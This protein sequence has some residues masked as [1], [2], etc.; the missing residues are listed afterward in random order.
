MIPYRCKQ[1]QHV[2]YSSGYKP[3]LVCKCKNT[4]FDQLVNICLLMPVGENEK[5]FLVSEPS[6]IP[7]LGQPASNRWKL[8][9]GS[10]TRPMHFTDQPAVATCKTCLEQYAKWLEA[11]PVKPIP[12]TEDAEVTKTLEELTKDQNLEIVFDFVIESGVLSM[13]IADFIPAL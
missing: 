3:K 6:G 11:N 4:E 8:A 13:T 1:C 9:C 10:S 7:E 5:A 2:T 12:P